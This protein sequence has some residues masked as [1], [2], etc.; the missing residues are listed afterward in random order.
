MKQS[1]ANVIQQFQN[2]VVKNIVDTLWYIRNANLHR[3]LQMEMVKNE[4]GK[5]AKKHEERLLHHADV[6][7]I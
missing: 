3:D 5:I 2:K 7:A 1:N 6:E 4:I